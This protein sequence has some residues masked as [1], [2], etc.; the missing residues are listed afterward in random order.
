MTGRGRQY[1]GR[2]MALVTGD[3]VVSSPEKPSLPPPYVYRYIIHIYN[4]YVYT[5][6]AVSSDV[7]HYQRTLNSPNDSSSSEFGGTG[8]KSRS[9][10]NS[11]PSLHPSRSPSTRLI[12]TMR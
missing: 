10:R 9:R 7:S 2:L 1:G 12:F 11:C 6:C 8:D 4:I 3:L 5:H